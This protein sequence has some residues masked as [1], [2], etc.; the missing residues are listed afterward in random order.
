MGRKAAEMATPKSDQPNQSENHQTSD[1]LTIKLARAGLNVA[2]EQA[3]PW[4]ILSLSIVSLFLALTWLGFFILLPAVL[5]MM[6]VFLFVFG[7]LLAFLMAIQS[8][9][10][11]FGESIKRLDHEAGAQHRP[12]TTVFDQPAGLQADA[13]TL[14][15]WRKHQR[16]A[17]VDVAN[18]KVGG[19]RLDLTLRDPYAIRFI[20]LLLAAAGFFIAYPE[21]DA[22]LSSA[23]DW[24]TNAEPSV[25]ARVD[26]W[27]NPPAYTHAPPIVLDFKSATATGN[28]YVKVPVGSD[29]VIR[30]SETHDLTMEISGGLVAK[31]ISTDTTASSG[32]E[33]HWTIQ[34]GGALTMHSGRTTLPSVLI[35]AIPDHPP[36]IRWNEPPTSSTSGTTLTYH[37]SDD[38]GVQSGEARVAKPQTGDNRYF[39]RR[40]PLLPPPHIDLA[41]PPDPRDGNGKTRIEPSESPWAGIPLELTLVAKD[42]AGQEAS[43]A[44]TDIILPQRIFTNSLARA[45]VEQRRLLAL[46]PNARSLVSEALYA[47][48]IAP[49]LFTPEAGTYLALRDISKTLQMAKTDTDL[50]DVTNELWSVATAIEDHDQGDGKKALDAARDALKKALERGASPDELKALTD[51]LKSALDHYLKG[52]AAKGRNNKNQADKNKPSNGKTIRSEDLQ[53][54]LD[55]MN[56]LAKKGA[57]DDAS[58]MLEALNS[59]IDQLQ[60]AEPQSVDPSQRE[61]SQALDELDKMMR[62]QRAL[63]DDT[64]KQGRATPKSGSPDDEKALADRQSQLQQRLDAL[65]KGLKQNGAPDQKSFD[66]AEEAMKQAEGS[67]AEGD[68]RN[69]IDAQGQAID[70]LRRGAQALAKELQGNEPG[71]GQA[72]G[73]RGQDQTGEGNG[74]SNDNDPLGR[75][76]RNLDPGDGAFQQGG[77]GGSLEKRSREVVEELRRRLSEPE[78][79]QEERDYLRRLLEQN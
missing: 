67:I 26:V 50:I 46:N 30:T 6:G 16:L 62:D 54:M 10:A 75:A 58:R 68:T 4:L 19:P 74:S 59:I 32:K 21:H 52:L 37:M 71:K 24:Q 66:E 11:T 36:A 5:K 78:R 1:R 45:L 35:E 9:R 70:S 22:L 18:I 77:K 14:S 38:Y 20:A 12:V 51:R 61:M 31:P 53:A 79:A 8:A 49:D 57:L 69:A 3:W 27:I 40:A 43:T 34:S 2:I 44:P 72:K 60:T 73:N 42:D 28:Q 13:L 76:T 48:M 65:R 56:D 17:L 15:L 55:R 63:R 33:W 29:L 25:L 41:L 7:S 23:F 47:L 39:G 64:F